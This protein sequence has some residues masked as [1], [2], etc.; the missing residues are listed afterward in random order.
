M[1]N[2]ENRIWKALI[3][4]ALLGVITEF[5]FKPLIVKPIEKKVEEIL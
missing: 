5:I 2:T 4:G 1:V 3:I